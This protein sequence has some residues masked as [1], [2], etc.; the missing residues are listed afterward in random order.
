MFK[1]SL[2]WFTND[3]RVHDNLALL[4][5]AKQSEQLIC[6][7]IVDP[8]WF[9]PNRYGLKSM[10]RYRKQFLHQSLVDLERALLNLGQ[11]LVVINRDPL[12]ALAILIS[13]YHIDAVFRSENAGYDEN[14]QW[15]LLR[16]RYPMLHFDE[17]ATHTLFEKKDLPFDLSKLPQ[18]FTKFRKLVEPLINIGDEHTTIHLPNPPF[19]EYPS[20]FSI[21]QKGNDHCSHFKGGVRESALQLSNY[22][23]KKLPGN[24]KNVRN[25]LDGW[26]NSTKISAWLANGSL[27]VK[28]VYRIISAYEVDVK[29]NES[30]YW[31]K[32]ELLWRE[33]FQWYAHAYQ[34]KLFALHGIKRKQ[35]HST[36]Y[37]ERFKRWSNGNTPYPL[38]NACMKQLNET[39]YLSNRGRQI[40]ASCFVNELNL[41]WRYGAA[42]F[43]ER[44]IDYDVASNWGNWQYLAGVGAD[45]RGKRHFDI[46][47][48]TNLY[49]PNESYIK[50]WKG[51]IGD[52]GLDSVDASDWPIE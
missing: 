49:D 50:K 36:F 24:Y 8:K 15:K 7:Y 3:L 18:S 33:Y 39:G 27:A 22:V 9:V 44:L 48:Q 1:T 38:V 51:D 2:Y 17:R 6:V 46:A 25:E 19:T 30:T 12:D 13:Q 21:L 42:Y 41:D 23:R 52:L 4:H 16:K 20:S 34:A 10:G 47:K 29:A 11:R 28:Q 14:Q 31:I 26:N 45:P 40:T 5:A 37:P 43:E 35:Y 32:F